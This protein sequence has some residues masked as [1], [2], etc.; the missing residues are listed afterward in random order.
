MEKL[1]NN[2]VR[3]NLIPCEVWIKITQAQGFVPVAS[4]CVWVKN[5]LGKQDFNNWLI[6]NEIS[7]EDYLQLKFLKEEPESSENYFKIP[8]TLSN[9][10]PLVVLIFKQEFYEHFKNQGHFVNPASFAYSLEIIEKTGSYNA[11][12]DIYRSIAF[13]YKSNRSELII[14]IATNKTLYATTKTRVDSGTRILEPLSHLCFKAKNQI[15]GYSQYSERLNE[16]P[17]KFHY[18]ERYQELKDIIFRLAQTFESPF[19]DKILPQFTRVEDHNSNMVFKST[20]TMVFGNGQTH[21]NAALGMREFG[22]YKKSPFTDKIELLFIFQNKDHANQLYLSLKK[23][24]R[25]FH[26]LLSYVGIPVSLAPQNEQLNYSDIDRLEEELHQ[27]IESELK[28]PEY[29]NKLAVV[30]GPFKRF[31]S[32]YDEIELYYRVKKMLLLKGIPS[33]FVN[34]STIKAQNFHYSLPNIAIAVLAKLGGIPWKLKTE[35]RNELI[36][37]FNTKNLN[38]EVFIGN[39]VFFDNEGQLGAVRGFTS[40]ASSGI[41][42]HLKQ[43]IKN[44]TEN[45]EIPERI[46]IHY[47]K[48]ASGKEIDA[49]D[50][51]LKSDLGLKIPYA[52]VEVNDT[53]SKL[54]ICFDMDYK[55][56]ITKSGTYVKVGFDEYLLFNNSRYRDETSLTLQELPIKLKI[57]Y[58]SSEVFSKKELISQVYEFSRLNWKGLKQNSLPATITFSKMIADFAAH[59]DGI[60]PDTIAAQNRP[61]FL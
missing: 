41:I 38:K 44:Y 33:Q 2:R 42:E 6:K 15:E 27:K 18:A 39:A 12:F 31:E 51:L 14:N 36:I 9:Q 55:F 3:L 5:Q 56:M 25:H 4:K 35:K 43:A 60:I 48:S 23:G 13:Q 7:E 57:S 10:S 16:A 20:N 24:L 29:T 30:I 21:I 52:I 1:I 54:D 50:K 58:M 34:P 17:Q 8:L 19:F 61:W 11:E 22:P 45:N 59:F 32:E 26:G 46:V 28:E 37:G 40:S 47:Y 49:I 53:R